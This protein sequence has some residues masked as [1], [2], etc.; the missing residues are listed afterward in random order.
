MRI[1]HSDLSTTPGTPRS[2]EARAQD[3]L[4]VNDTDDVSGKFL[5]KSFATCGSNILVCQI[6]SIKACAMTKRRYSKTTASREA[7]K[8]RAL[9]NDLVRIVQIINDAIKTEEEHAG[10]FDPLQ[11]SVSAACEATCSTPEQLDRYHCC[12]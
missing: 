2:T 5:A 8:T 3:F 12:A 7:A 1:S 11:I 10:V 9:I 4:A 6:G